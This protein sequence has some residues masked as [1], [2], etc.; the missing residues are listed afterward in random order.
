MRRPLQ[1]KMEAKTEFMLPQPR[2]AWVT[3]ITA[4]VPT[5]ST[6]IKIKV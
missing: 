5:E 1:R 2:N 3:V 4:E 6:V